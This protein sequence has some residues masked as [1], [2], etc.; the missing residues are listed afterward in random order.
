VSSHAP[1]RPDLIRPRFDRRDLPWIL[2]GTLLAA[3][4]GTVAY[5]QL[6]SLHFG[7][8]RLYETTETTNDF[9]ETLRGPVTGWY[10]PVTVAL[11]AIAG[12]VA[13]AAVIVG[14]WKSL[15]FYIVTTL[16]LIA[17]IEMTQAAGQKRTPTSEVDSVAIALRC[18]ELEVPTAETKPTT[19]SGKTMQPLHGLLF[20]QPLLLRQFS[21]GSSDKRAPLKGRAH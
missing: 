12:L 20:R 13:T 8:W 14:R 21:C 7:A 15:V 4:A 16:F 9:A 19:S 3:L 17:A 2:L 11:A 1:S 5:N 18:K 10:Q 6:F